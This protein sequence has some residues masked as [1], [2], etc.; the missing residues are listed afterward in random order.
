MG[1]LIEGDTTRIEK[2]FGHVKKYGPVFS[3]LAYLVGIVYFCLLSHEELVH[4]TYI[5]EN[6]LMPGLIFLQNLI[7]TM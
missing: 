4:G 5:S 7:L 6:A 1:S 2:I 3:I